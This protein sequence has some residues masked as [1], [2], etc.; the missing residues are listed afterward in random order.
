MKQKDMENKKLESKKVES[1]AAESKQTESKTIESKKAKSQT[2]KSQKPESQKIESHKQ[3]SSKTKTKKLE[4]KSIDSEIL[5]SAPESKSWDSQNIDSGGDYQA[6][7]KALDSSAQTKISAISTTSADTIANATQNTKNAT[8]AQNTNTNTTTSTASASAQNTNSTA[9]IAT[10]ALLDAFPHTLPI[11]AGY[12]AMGATFGILLE[13][14][15]FGAIYAALMGIFIYAGAMQFACVG[16]LAAGASVLDSFII[17]LMINSRQ[18]FYALSM[19]GKLAKTERK[20]RWYLIFSLTD[21]TFALLNLKTPKKHINNDWFMF[22]IAALNQ[23]YWVVGCVLGALA[24]SY[25]TFDARGMEF[26][27]SAIFVVIF[28]DQWSS[29]KTHSPAIIGVAVSVIC[30]VAFGKEA[31]LLPSLVAICAIL[32]YLNANNSKKALE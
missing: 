31:F 32:L 22:W 9:H 26:V 8:A 13:K 29:S 19:L 24:S 16:L 20:K 14:E 5:D 28:I 3:K 18:I 25:F 30:L 27:M 10:Q 6:D 21:E 1:K 15:G 7:S 23:L 12:I 17:A 4:S 11:L 2:T